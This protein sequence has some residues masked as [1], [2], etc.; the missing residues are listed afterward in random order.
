MSLKLEI[1]DNFL[2]KED[3][4]QLQ[5][6]KLKETEDGK[7]NVYVKKVNREGKVSGTGMTEETALELQK[8]YHSKAMEILQR[9]YPEKASLYEYSEFGITDTGT[10]YNF[11]IHND[12]P[13][14]LLSG[15]V[16]LSPEK[17]EGTKFYKNKKG[18]GLNSINWKI[19]RS[20]FF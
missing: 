5:S 11:P 13:N 15:V 17:S 20:V 6:L 18:E 19:N 3:L 4:N 7:M 2:S 10:N 8:N 16:F 1:I 14:K 9:L 12:T